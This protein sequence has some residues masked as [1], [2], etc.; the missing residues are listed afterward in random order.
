M[1]ARR[2]LFITTAALVV[3]PLAASAA[4][5]QTGGSALVTVGSRT[6]HF[7][8]NKQNEP[9]V[10]IDPLDPA[11][12][13]AGANEE[14]DVAPCAGSSCPFT[15]GVGTSGVYFSTDGGARWTQPTYQG[16]WSARTGTPGIGPI[17]T[18]PGYLQAGLVSDGDPA[19]AFGPR[20]VNGHFSWANGVRLYYGNLTANFPGAKAFSGFEAVAVSR[21]DNLAAAMA[22]DASAWMAPV[23]VTRQNSALFS[24]KDAVWADNVASSPFF[25]RVYV[26]NIAFRSE[27]ISP[28][29]LA[30]PVM[31]DTSTDGG[32]TW[33]QRQ[34]SQAT[35]N[36]RTGGRQDC[37]LRT[38]SHGVVYL[39][40]HNF[41]VQLNSDTIVQQR[42]FDGGATFTRPQ[43]IA[44][45]G[46]TGQ[47]D[48][49]QARFTIDGV[50]G[51][52][53]SSY[54][55]FDIAN[56]APTGA[57]ATNEIAVTWTDA[58]AGLNKEQAFLETSTNGGRTYSAPV[59]ISQAGDRAN[60]PAIAITPDGTRLWLTYNAY[61]LPWQST[62]S[63]AR[64]ELGV[65]RM[66]AIGAGGAAGTFTTVLRGATGDARGSSANNLTSEFLGDYNDI[67]ATATS[68]LAVWNDTRRAA[69]CPAIDAYRQS[70]LTSTPLTKPAPPTAC[71]ATFGNSDI[72]SG[73]F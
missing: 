23:I 2:G 6:T 53:T 50:A 41:N 49:V 54:P 34:V 31:V 45:I 40:Y 1:S 19:L 36:I 26:C 52:R 55:S 43:V 3:L 14:I 30:G 16:G 39:M 24:D 68:A 7:P 9:A 29:S 73:S 69:D 72:F 57:G 66:A 11:I 21:T 58:R 71:P 67:K 8:Q 13:V 46:Q 5:A 59:A 4:A 18:L 51:A 37:A 62:T 28:N 56:G 48:P 17:G 70:L 65:V 63:A 25:G 20:P 64:P 27:E 12:A 32:S 42:S 35:N 38:D 22:N 15:P 61:L 44:V 47:F 60:Q 10:A 33:V